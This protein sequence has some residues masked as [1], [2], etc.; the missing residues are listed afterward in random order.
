MS[1]CHQATFPHWFLFNPV[2]QLVTPSSPALPK[3]A[4]LSPFQCNQTPFN[5][6]A[7]SYQS[8]INIHYCVTDFTHAQKKRNNPL[9]PLTSAEKT[10]HLPHLINFTNRTRTLTHT[11]S[12]Q[13][14]CAVHTLLA[15]ATLPPRFTGLNHGS[16]VTQ[17]C[18]RTG[19]KSERL[20]EDQTEQRKMRK[21]QN[22]SQQLPLRWID[23]GNMPDEQ[24]FFESR[25][26]LIVVGNVFK[27][28][29]ETP[30]K[31]THPGGKVCKCTKRWQTP[32]VHLNKCFD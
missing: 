10:L 6:R 22:Y 18:S 24:S 4:A 1:I 12:H 14:V 25:C 26:L 8:A 31:K 5:L 15:A 21:E 29:A 2:A 7:L 20:N 23:G 11:P 3:C 27:A 28:E 16:S 32:G 30:R 9:H 13:D 17:R 19:I